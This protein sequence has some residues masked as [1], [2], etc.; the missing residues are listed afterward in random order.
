MA[1]AEGLRR[2]GAVTFDLSRKIIHV[3]IGTWIVPTALLFDSPYWAAALPAVFVVLNAVSYR[4]KLVRAM[5][6]EAGD[7]LGTILF[8][9]SFALLIV[10]FWN[11]EGGRAALTAGILVLAWGDAAAALIGKR[12]GKHRYRVGSGYRSWEGSF[13]MFVFS[14]LAI[15]VAGQWLG[16]DSYSIAA[17]VGGAALATILEGTSLWG[18]DNLFVPLGTTLLLRGLA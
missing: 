15:F 16:A 5:D 2:S 12:W 1:I 6:E 11:Q 4:F 10:L 17:I 7:N 8:P 3:G 9:L 13:A 18:L 14:G